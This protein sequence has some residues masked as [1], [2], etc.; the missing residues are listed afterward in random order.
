MKRYY[1]EN[2]EMKYT[3]VQEKSRGFA[4]MK[5]KGEKGITQ[6]FTTGNGQTFLHKGQI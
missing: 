2:H 4:G 3:K 5:I 6:L 1:L